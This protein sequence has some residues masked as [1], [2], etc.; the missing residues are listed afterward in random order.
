MR[1]YVLTALIAVPPLMAACGSNDEPPTAANPTPTPT[2]STAPTPTP[3]PAAFA[4]PL[5]ASSNPN[6][7]CAEASSRLANQVNLAIDTLMVTHPEIFNLNDLSGGNPRVV[8]PT[9]YYE[10][11]TNELGRTY[12]ICTLVMTE[13][14]SIKASNSYSE[15]WNV[16]TSGNFVRRR[17]QGTCWP[18]WF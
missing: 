13:E 1:R 8:N 16:L 12:G 6:L 4:C 11:L 5:P 18:S 15:D 7:D 9:K 2:V 3:T 14:I 17:Y 10:E